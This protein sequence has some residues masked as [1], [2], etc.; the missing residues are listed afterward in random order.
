MTQKEGLKWWG[1]WE[2]GMGGMD[3]S[4]GAVSP[5]DVLRQTTTIPSPPPISQDMN[6]YC[7]I[8]RPMTLCFSEW[9]KP[10][11]LPGWKGHLMVCVLYPKLRFRWRLLSV[12][13]MYWSPEQ[14]VWVWESPTGNINFIVKRCSSKNDPFCGVRYDIRE[15]L[16][17]L[18]I[19]CLLGIETV[20]MWSLPDN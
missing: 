8:M 1:G 4:R 15:Y 19:K 16:N 7:L 10:L 14:W 18:H 5:E 3:G 13:K 11:F 12:I 17:A 9:D 2:W 6:E 20:G